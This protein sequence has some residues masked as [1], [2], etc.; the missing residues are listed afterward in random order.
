MQ[1]YARKEKYVIMES[2]P[3]TNAM[4][5]YNVAL[6]LL[7]VGWLCICEWHIHS[8][9]QTGRYRTLQ[10][11]GKAVGLPSDDDMGNSEVGHNALGSGEIV[12]QGAKLVDK[13]L[14]KGDIFDGAGWKHIEPSFANN[15]V[16]LIGLLTK[17]GVHARMD[18]LLLL[19]RGLASANAKRVRVHVLTDGRD[20]PDGTSIEYLKELEAEIKD[21]MATSAS[22]IDIKIASG[23]GRMYVTMDR[24]EADWSIVERGWHAHVLGEAG[25]N[26]FRSAGEAVETLRKG[27]EVS[28]QNLE[29]FVVVDADDKPVGTVEDGDAVVLFNFRSDRC[30]EISKA[31]EYED[32]S[33]FDR[34]RFP[35][36]RYVGMMQYDGD[37]HLPANYLVSAPDI[38]GTAGE[39]LV[40]N[41][42]KTFACSETQKFGHVTFFW[43]GNRS[44]YFDE[45]LETYVEIPSDK[46]EF[47]KLPHMKADEIT[48]AGLEALRSGK[49]DIVRINYANPDMVGHTG[50]LKATIDACA[51]VD[52]CL[53][54]LLDCVDE[55]NGRWLVTS[56]H[57]NADDM[58][59]RAKKTKAPLFDKETGEIVQ[60]KSHTLAPVPVAIGGTGLPANIMFRTDLPNAGLAN[61]T[62]TYL[63]L[64]GFEAPATK[65]ASL[66]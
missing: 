32:F 38:R 8:G 41:N 30:I 15:T 47:N 63:N 39:Y 18:Q 28:D 6:C 66:I 43:N 53:K 56:D 61:V 34:V 33:S 50:D 60:C 29:P 26:R 52:A 23:G 11:H 40:H 20:V 59:Q 57:G 1:A 58:A 55:L 65:E 37:L 10:A 21:I 16:H 5:Y 14:A 3:L 54:K 42:I 22:G 4:V 17:G 48:A 13:A 24:Y 46:V 64:V 36:T 31:F 2:T 27:G 51:K 35:K 9:L 44:G 49:F 62:A 7:L 25:S 12:D 45:R 19:L